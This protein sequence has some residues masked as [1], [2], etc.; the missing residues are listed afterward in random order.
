ML[1]KL[2]MKERRKINEYYRRPRTNK[3]KIK[4]LESKET[5]R[6]EE[7]QLRSN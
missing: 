1:W 2:N 3:S 7:I 5:H 6:K 4:S